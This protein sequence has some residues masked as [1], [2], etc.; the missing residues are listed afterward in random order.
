MGELSDL[1]DLLKPL[2]GI[3]DVVNAPAECRG[4]GF[5]IGFANSGT[6]TTVLVHVPDADQLQEV[7]SKSRPLA[8]A[9]AAFASKQAGGE[10]LLAMICRRCGGSMVWSVG[11]AERDDVEEAVLCPSCTT[12]CAVAGVEAIRDELA[13]LKAEASGSSSIADGL[14]AVIESTDDVV[15]FHRDPFGVLFEEALDAE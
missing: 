13:E 8:M 12:I 11:K 2:G 6:P 4:L 9:A 5:R 15:R 3:A 10:S 14:E 1:Q 7:I